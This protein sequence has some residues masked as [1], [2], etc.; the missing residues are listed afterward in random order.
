LSFATL[1]S[2][3]CNLV[4]IELE[5]RSCG[6]GEATALPGYGTETFEQISQVLE[7]ASLQ[8]KGATFDQGWQ[9]VNQIYSRSPFAASAIG[10]ALEFA[11]KEFIL[12]KELNIPL[13]YPVSASRH[14]A[15]LIE[16]VKLAL[17]RGYRTV[18][19]KIGKDIDTD[20]VTAKALLQAPFNVRYRFDANQ[21]YT[22]DDARQFLDFLLDMAPERI[23]Y[24]EQPLPKGSWSSDAI[25]CKEYPD[26]ILL[27]ESIYDVSNIRRAADIGAGY[28]KLKLFKTKGLSHLLDITR[29]AREMGLKVVLGNG[30]AT[31]VCNMAEAIA[32][33]SEQDLYFGAYEGNGY[34]KLKELILHKELREHNG[35][36][37]WHH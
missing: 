20:L 29:Y 25:L 18:K 32:Y 23:D 31:D 6:I 28:I 7:K 10:T 3:K 1:T 26:R 14:T 35:R 16:K 4:E 34:L 30:V 21:G 5:D 36:L 11:I 27:D 19:V 37:V 12:P 13:L 33:S 22:V 2:F 15:L 8:L 9:L 24:L 17:N